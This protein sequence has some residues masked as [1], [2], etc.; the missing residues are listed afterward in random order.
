MQAIFDAVI[1]CIPGK[2]PKLSSLASII[3]NPLFE[4]AVVKVQLGDYGSLSRDKRATLAKLEVSNDEFSRDAGDP[5]SFVNQTLKRQR[6]LSNI[7]I[8]RYM[9]L[10][11]LLPTSKICESFFLLLDTFFGIK[12]STSTPCR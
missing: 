3:H 5:L 6:Q 11:F 8:K 7:S 2:E 9:D 1:G 4:F 12:A 10:R